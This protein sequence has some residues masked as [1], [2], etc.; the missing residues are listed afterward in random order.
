MIEIGAASGV[1]PNGIAMPLA[2]IVNELL[3]NAVKYGG[4][5]RRAVRVGLSERDAMFELYV[6]D[7]GEGYDL[8]SVKEVSSGLQLVQGLARQLRGSISVTQKPS[9][10]TMR[11][12]TIS[13]A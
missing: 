9:R 13:M 7:E 8:S 12:P 2:L 10:V 3:T 4:R 5:E 1:L 11:F 6:E